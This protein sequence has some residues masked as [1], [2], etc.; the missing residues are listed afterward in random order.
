MSYKNIKYKIFVP[1]LHPPY[2]T[3][4]ITN[5]MNS[6]MIFNLKNCVELMKPVNNLIN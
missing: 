1:I 2:Q 5:L 4:K 6:F 3:N